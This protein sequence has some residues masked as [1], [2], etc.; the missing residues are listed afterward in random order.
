MAGT[1]NSSRT[2]VVALFNL[3]AGS[4]DILERL[5]SELRSAIPNLGFAFGQLEDASRMSSEHS[6]VVVEIGDALVNEYKVGDRICTWGGTAYSG[7]VTVNKDAVQRIP[8]NM[9]FETAAS[10]PIVYATVYYGLVHL[11]RLQQGQSVLIHAAAGGVGQAAVMLAKHIGATIFVTVGSNE[12][13]L[14]VEHYDIAE[15]HIFSSRHLSFVDGV[16][17]L[18]NSRGVDVVLDSLAGVAL[19]ETFECLASLGR[20]IEIGKRDILAYSR[21]DMAMFNKASHLHQST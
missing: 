2:L 21:L 16:K 10:I 17:R 20:F 4:L 11:A 1:D 12:E 7:S 15:D 5:K 3:L 18:T 14:V 19:H 6:G 8:D 9:T 13:K